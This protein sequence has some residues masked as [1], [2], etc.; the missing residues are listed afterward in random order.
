MNSTQYALPPESIV[1]IAFQTGTEKYNL[2]IN[3]TEGIISLYT[4]KEDK[5]NAHVFTKLI[6]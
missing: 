5:E 3:T 1:D 6:S 2:H 4:L